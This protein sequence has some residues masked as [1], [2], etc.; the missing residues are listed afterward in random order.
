VLRR[1]LRSNGGK[2]SVTRDGDESVCDEALVRDCPC[3]SGRAYAACCEPFHA[4]GEP[5]DAETLMRSRYSAYVV[6]A[7]A[8][9]FRTL[10]PDHD[11]HAAG[12]AALTKTF[13]S[14][15]KL[16]R[17]EALRVLDRDGPDAD[18]VAR[19]LFHVK[20]KRAGKDASFVELSSFA[21]DGEGWRYV[22]GELRPGNAAE[23]LTI[24]S[25]LRRAVKE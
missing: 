4:G 1:S 19:V 22:G 20:M 25:F 23:G 10:H 7:H 13:A 11:D 21:H 2:V 12:E 14:N 24:A 9:L 18:G 16:L 8:Y 5:H 3:G 15:T 17:Y 6:G